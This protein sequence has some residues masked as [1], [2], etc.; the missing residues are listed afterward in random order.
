MTLRHRDRTGIFAT[1]LQTV[2]PYRCVYIRQPAKNG[3]CLLVGDKPDWSDL[4]RPYPF[5]Y[6]SLVPPS[7]DMPAT[8]FAK[9]PA[10]L[11]P[12]STDMVAVVVAQHLELKV[13]VG[14]RSQR[15]RVLLQ[16]G[17]DSGG[18]FGDVMVWSAGRFRYYDMSNGSLTDVRTDRCR[19]LCEGVTEAEAIRTR[20]RHTI[21]PFVVELAGFVDWE[22]ISTDLKNGLRCGVHLA[23]DTVAHFT[24]RMPDIGPH[25]DAA[26]CAKHI[27][28]TC[29]T[30]SLSAIVDCLSTQ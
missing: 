15:I 22:A 23:P 25:A 8:L 14:D 12:A 2:M 29:M 21:I 26:W 7:M 17:G 28:Y 9:S 1:T 16:S 3:K 10:Y 13:L 4:S 30:G 27:S 5:V 18:E 11:P 20:S 6:D 24:A 19:N